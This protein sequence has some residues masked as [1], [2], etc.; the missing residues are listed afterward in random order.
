MRNSFNIKVGDE[1]KQI[2]ESNKNCKGNTHHNS[3]QFIISVSTK[4]EQS[5]LKVNKECV[6]A[7]GVWELSVPSSQFCCELK[8]ALKKKKK[9]VFK[10]E[11]V[12]MQK[13]KMN[14]YKLFK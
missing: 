8:T 10:K 4:Q 1:K 13:T 11:N 5:A 14:S 6:R 7:E 12:N 2:K 3:L 9:T